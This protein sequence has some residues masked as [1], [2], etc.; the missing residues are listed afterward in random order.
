MLFFLT[1][2]SKSKVKFFAWDEYHKKK[3]TEFK[4]KS[5]KPPGGRQ[6]QMGHG[7][8]GVVEV[9]GWIHQYAPDGLRGVGGRIL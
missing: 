7:I 3:N 6:A 4:P 5:K 9:Y 8:P 1:F 2:R